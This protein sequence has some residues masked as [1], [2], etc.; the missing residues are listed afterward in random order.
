MPTLL[1]PCWKSSPPMQTEY[2][3]EWILRDGEV[4]KGAGRF[5]SVEDAE[6]D[7]QLAFRNRQHWS[8]NYRIVESPKP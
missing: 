2:M 4:V 7:V 3:I 1:N 5:A 8:K 6:L